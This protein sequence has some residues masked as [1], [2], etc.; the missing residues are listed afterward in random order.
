MLIIFHCVGVR[1]AVDVTYSVRR[2]RFRI[3]CRS[4]RGI[5][6]EEVVGRQRVK[7]TTVPGTAIAAAPAYVLRQLEP[8]DPWFVVNRAGRSRLRDRN[9]TPAL[10]PEIDGLDPLEAMMRSAQARTK[11]CDRTHGGAVLRARERGEPPPPPLWIM[12]VAVEHAE[13]GQYRI[14]VV[15]PAP[16]RL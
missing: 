3:R 5:Y 4:D 9:N 6:C 13:L 12:F 1:I 8:G 7:A 11:Y 10:R 2:I 14:G 15:Q 16:R